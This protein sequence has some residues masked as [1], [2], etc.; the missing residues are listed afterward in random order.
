MMKANKKAKYG[1][2]NFEIEFFKNLIKDKDDFIEAL[3][4]LAENYTRCGMYDQGLNI[5]LKLTT[6]RPHDPVVWYN[7]ACSYALTKSYDLAIETLGKAV[8]LGY[9]DYE[10][11]LR[12]KDL[13]NIKQDVRFKKILNKIK[14][15]KNKRVNAKVN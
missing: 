15:R 4:P 9:R 2:L 13:D 6:L 10:Y 14:G 12:D 5:D 8:K 11:M 3:F 1:Q 7:L